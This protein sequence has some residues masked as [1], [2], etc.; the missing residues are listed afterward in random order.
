M[1]MLFTVQRDDLVSG[2]G[3]PI[4]VWESCRRWRWCELNLACSGRR[5]TLTLSK[6]TG[7]TTSYQSFNMNFQTTPLLLAEVGWKHSTA[8]LLSFQHKYVKVV[9]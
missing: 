7:R 5:F 2:V 4:L 9:T 6:G 8:L 1:S 3:I